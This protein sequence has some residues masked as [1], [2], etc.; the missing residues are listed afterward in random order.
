M[1]TTESGQRCIGDWIVDSHPLGQG[2]FAVVWKATHQTTGRPAA[3][4][5]TKL[6][7]RLRQSLESEISVLSRISHRN[8]VQL[9]EVLETHGRMFLIMEYCSGGDLSQ[10][11]KSKKKIPEND[12]RYLMQDLAAGLREMW[13]HHLVHVSFFF[14]KIFY[15]NLLACIRFSNIICVFL[16]TCREI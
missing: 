12:V 2:S 13:L 10:Y 6:N 15:V 1:S 16:S 9:Y 5:E 4:K 14:L 3:I 8:V 7:A 11:F